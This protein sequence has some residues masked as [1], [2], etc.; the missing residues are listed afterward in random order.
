MSIKDETLKALAALE[1]NQDW[2]VVKQFFATELDEARDAAISVLE[3][4]LRARSAG[5]AVW[6]RDF[7]KQASDPRAALRLRNR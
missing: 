1:G 3:P 4:E 7:V 6:L 2:E 5:R